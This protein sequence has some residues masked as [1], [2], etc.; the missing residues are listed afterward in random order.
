MEGRGVNVA[1]V[2]SGICWLWYF[3]PWLLS[4]QHK[5]TLYEKDDRFGGH[6][7]TATVQGKSSSVAKTDM[8]FAVSI[9]NGKTEYAGT[10]FNGLFA[11]RGNVFNLPFWRTP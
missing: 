4:R 6:S 3:L 8:S 10:A 7:H 9:S 11:Q 2:G 1:V 5:V